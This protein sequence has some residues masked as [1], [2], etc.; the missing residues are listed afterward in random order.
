MAAKTDKKTLDLI[1][2]VKKQ[3]AEIAKADR[4]NWRT[5]C[6]FAYQE[7]SA[8]TQNLQVVSNVRDLIGIAAFLIERSKSYKDAATAIGVDNP[9]EFTWCNFTLEDWLEDL[10]TRMAKIQVAARRQKLAAVEE[11]LNKI[12]SP[13]LRAEMELEAITAELGS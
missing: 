11:R 10:K 3:R 8:N 4:S 9:P 12:I 13:E 1:N 6:S 5:N 7:G 2:E